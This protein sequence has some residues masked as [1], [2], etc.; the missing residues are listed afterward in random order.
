MIDI[1]PAILT[2]D[3]AVFS[4][5]LNMFLNYGNIDIDIIEKPFADNDTLSVDEVL[6]FNELGKIKDLGFHLMVSDPE[7]FVKKILESRDNS[8][9]VYVHQ[10]SIKD[11]FQYLKSRNFFLGVAIK[12]ESELRELSFYENFDE[13][14]IMSVSIGFQGGKFDNKSLEKVDRLRALGYNGRVSLD[15]GINLSTAKALRGH[16]VDRVS[17]GSFF[18]EATDFESSYKSLDEALNS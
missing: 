9:R 18:Q 1:Y 3:K 11:S 15:G 6:S 7:V 17:V 8:F 10:E 13:V 5:S 16:S 12:L 14:Q 4:N 2:K